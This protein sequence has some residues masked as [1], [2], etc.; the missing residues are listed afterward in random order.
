[1]EVTGSWA[2][3]DLG[4]GALSCLNGC[5]TFHGAAASASTR[6]VKESL[7]VVPTHTH[8]IQCVFFS[9]E[10]RP[11]DSGSRNSAEPYRREGEECR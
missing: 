1:M 5:R 6:P 4:E 11:G 8:W 9:G 10:G 3:E 7:F 2:R